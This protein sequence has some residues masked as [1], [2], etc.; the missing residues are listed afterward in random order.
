MS[1]TNGNHATGFDHAKL[2]AIIDQGEVPL[3][4][5][6]DIGPRP[7]DPALVELM[8]R[9]RISREWRDEARARVHRL[10]RRLLRVGGTE[11]DA[12]AVLEGEVQ[13]LV[14]KR[15]RRKKRER[16]AIP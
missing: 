9:A 15:Q 14:D 7:V 4:E 2:D 5:V 1:D 3:V 13:K 16:T 12:I 10:V 8:E 6:P 11:D